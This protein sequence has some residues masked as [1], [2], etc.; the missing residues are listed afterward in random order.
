MRRW[1]G[2]SEDDVNINDAIEQYLEAVRLYEATDEAQSYTV[3]EIP[4]VGIANVI[5]E[6]LGL[7]TG[8]RMFHLIDKPGKGGRSPLAASL[9]WAIFKR[10]G[11]R[12]LECFSDVD[13]TIDHIHPVS[14]G[15]LDNEYN[16]RTLCR[17]CNSQKGTKV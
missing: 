16:L 3:I 6:S 4:K 11:Y 7:P 17:S 2:G 10:D 14:K 8:P 9:R 1:S 15:G 13:L 5:L 12:C